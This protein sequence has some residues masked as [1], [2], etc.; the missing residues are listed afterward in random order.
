MFA[1]DAGE[2]SGS[3]RQRCRHPE[4]LL[5]YWMFLVDK[6]AVLR[7]RRTTGM[8]VVASGFLPNLVVLLILH[9][10]AAGGRVRGFDI[11]AVGRNISRKMTSCSATIKN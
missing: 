11:V 6:I 7:A 9:R 8:C 5:A 2:F 4:R 3:R 1:T 10:G